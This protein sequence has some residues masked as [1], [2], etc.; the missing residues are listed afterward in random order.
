VNIGQ[1]GYLPNLPKPT[2]PK[3]V[4][5]I[6]VGEGPGDDCLLILWSPV[7]FDSVICDIG[8]FIILELLLLFIIII[9]Y[10][11]FF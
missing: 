7:D 3:I 9:Y 10:Y 6:Q 8:C 5:I 1:N 11:Y 4:E 2:Q